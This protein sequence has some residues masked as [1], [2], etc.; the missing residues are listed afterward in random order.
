MEW[1]RT[2]DKLPD[3]ERDVLAFWSEWNGKPTRFLRVARIQH[4]NKTL[5]LHWVIEGRGY[6]PAPSHWIPIPK[7][8]LY[9]ED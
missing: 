8:P 2:A 1:I 9:S 7:L 4:S 6:A 5:N 3:T